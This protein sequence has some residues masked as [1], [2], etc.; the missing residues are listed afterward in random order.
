MIK[1][2]FNKKTRNRQLYKC[3]AFL[4]LTTNVTFEPQIE[5]TRRARL[6]Q[7][8][9]SGIS[10]DIASAWQFDMTIRHEQQLCNIYSIQVV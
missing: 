9:E 2:D 6:F 7:T 4:K 10:P 1:Q 8:T 3:F 5:A